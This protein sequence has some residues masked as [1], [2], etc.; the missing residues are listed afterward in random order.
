M[1][2]SAATASDCPV[3]MKRAE[4]GAMALEIWSLLAPARAILHLA[5]LGLVH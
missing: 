4:E 1:I 2:R 5:S 3:L